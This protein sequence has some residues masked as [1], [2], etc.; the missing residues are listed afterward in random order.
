[1]FRKLW[2]H[3]RDDMPKKG[4]GKAGELDPLMLPVPLQT[5]LDALYGHYEKTFRLWEEAEIPVRRASSSFATTHR[6]RSWCTSTFRASSGVRERTQ[7]VQMDGWA[8]FATSTTTE[9]GSPVPA[10]C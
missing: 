6:P 5:A 7:A 1:M 8:C 4:R 9:T 2:E 3:I 10:R